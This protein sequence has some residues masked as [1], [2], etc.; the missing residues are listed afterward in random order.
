M[1]SFVE[2]VKHIFMNICAKSCTGYK[3]GFEVPEAFVPPSRSVRAE[4]DR[5]PEIEMQGEVQG[6]AL[7]D[8][9]G[10]VNGSEV[11]VRNEVH[12][13]GAQAALCASR[14]DEGGEAEELPPELEIQFLSEQCQVEA[15]IC[16]KYKCK[17]EWIGEVGDCIQ[18]LKR[19]HTLVRDDLL[20]IQPHGKHFRKLLELYPIGNQK[21]KSTPM[22][23]TLPVDPKPLDSAEHAK[24]RSAVGILLYLSPD[25]VASQNAVR[26]LAPAMSAPTYGHVKLLKHLIG[27]LFGTASH[28]LGFDIPMPGKG[29]IAQST[30]SVLELFTDSD[31]SGC[32][33]TRRSTSSNAILLNGH[34]LASASRTQKVIFLSSCE[35][36]YHSYVSGMAD[37][38]FIS[39]ALEFLGVQIERR[40]FIDS[41]AARGLLA[42][43]GV[44]KV[45][46]MQGKLLW[47][48]SLYRDGYMLAHPVD[49][50]L[51]V[52]D[53]NTKPLQ[54][55]RVYCLIALLGM[56][57][58]SNG[59]QI[60]GQVQLD[61]VRS[62]IAL[63]QRPTFAALHIRSHA[64]QFVGHGHA[65]CSRSARVA[66][67]HGNWRRGHL[68]P[69]STGMHV[70]TL[71]EVCHAGRGNP[72]PDHVARL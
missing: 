44:G 48:Q 10:Q 39:S 43:Q 65:H 8:A 72:V 25:I 68:D 63:R 45:R 13:P 27:Y 57:D 4:A 61:E 54:H 67:R 22:P 17:V 6:Q 36:E 34:L 12:D 46:H 15:A 59:Y 37:F 3:L 7:P 55:D 33:E 20:I 31:W 50:L 38:I 47:C 5:L 26:V 69:V 1:I 56:R 23:A 60:V 19:D 53:L 11:Q 58:L 42:R 64:A 24:Y 66:G 29:V 52:A 28:V 51:N 32:K 9:S 49:A 18:F 14:A 16:S 21:P 30:A 40:T 35:A 62:R 71:S 2:I 70:Q 41:S